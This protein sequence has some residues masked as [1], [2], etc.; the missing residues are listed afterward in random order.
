MRLVEAS[1]V[2]RPRFPRSQKAGHSPPMLC[3][4]GS[5]ALIS[6]IPPAWENR[7]GRGEGNRIEGGE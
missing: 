7:G 4:P 5:L 6:T 3:S 2:A 1:Y